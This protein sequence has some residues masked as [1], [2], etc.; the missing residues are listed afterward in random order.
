MF[1]IVSIPAAAQETPETGGPG[2]AL[3]FERSVP[4]D[5]QTEI[6]APEIT[7]DRQG[8]LVGIPQP[9]REGEV[10]TFSTFSAMRVAPRPITA[11]VLLDNPGALSSLSVGG[12]VRTAVRRVQSE[13]QNVINDLEQLGVADTQSISL[14]ANALVVNIDASQIAE[15]EALPGVRAVVPDQIGYLDN[16]NSVPFINAVSA[17]QAAGGYTGTGVRIGIIDSGIDY[18]HANFG[19]SGDPAVFTANNTFTIADIGFNGSKVVGGYDFVGSSW[20]SGGPLV[21]DDDPV[22]CNGH[23]SHVAGTAAGF[24]VDDSGNT[25]TG[26]Y[27]ASTDFSSMIIGPGVAPE[28]DL[29]ALKIGGCG[30]AVSFA[31][32][33]LALEFAID[34]NGD[35]NPSDHLDVINNSYGGAYGTALEIL[36]DQMDYAA[37]MGVIVVSS[38]GNEG[39]VYFVT[40]APGMSEWSISTASSVS[41]TTFNGLEITTGDGSFLNYPATIAASLSQ[42]GALGSFG[43]YSLRLVGGTGN[44]QGCAVGDYTG[45]TGEVG[46]IIWSAAASGCGSGTRMTNAVNAGNVAG[47]VVVTANPADFPFISLA[48]TY[49]GGP[50][51]IPCVSVSGADGALLQANP[52]NFTVRFDD[53]LRASL[54]VSLGDTLSNF[55]SRGPRTQTGTGEVILKPD[56]TAPGQNIVSTGVGTGNGPTTLS[57]TSM[58]SPHIT[59]VAALMRQ[60]HP[61]WSVSEIKA[62]M[63]N[64]AFHDLWTQPDQSG[65]NYGLS[66]IGAGR[67]DIALALNTDVIAYDSSYP[68]RVSVSFGLVEIV[69]TVSI[70]RSITIANKGSSSETYDVSFQQANDTPG[71]SFSVSP[72]Q[73]T[74]GAGGTASVQVT[75]TANKAAMANANIPDP[76]TPLTQNGAF[77]NL[78]RHRI[79]EEGGY[80]VLD[81]LSSVSDLRVPVHAAPRPAS[82]MAADGDLVIGGGDTG[83]AA[84]RLAGNEVFTGLNFPQDVISLVTAFELVD[85][86]PHGQ[87]PLLDGADIQYIGVTSDYLANWAACS[88]DTT[89][90]INNTTVYFG[91]TTYG[92][93][94]TA[95]G[96]NTW[97]DIGVDSDENNAYNATVFNFETG[98]LINADFTDTIMSWVT[99]GNSWLTSNGAPVSAYFINDLP[100]NTLE[101]YVFNNNVLVFPVAATRLG[102]SAANTDFWFDVRAF[103]DFFEGDWLPEAA[104]YWYTYD[105]ANPAYS[106]NDAAGLAGGPY[107]GVPTWDDLDGNFIPVDYTVAGLTDLPPILLLHHHNAADASVGRAE[108]V[109]VLRGTEMDAVVTK[110]VDDETPAEAATV[111]FEITVANSG[112]GILQDPVLVDRLPIGLTY[113]SDTCPGTSIV[114][115]GALGTEI[116]CEM[117][118]SSIPSGFSI[119]YD[120]VATVDSGTSGTTLTNQVALTSYNTATVDI[121]VS[122][123]LSA[124][125]VCVDGIDGQC[126][127]PPT[128]ANIQEGSGV[129]ITPG[130]TIDTPI[131]T[132]S[133]T[134]DQPVRGG[135]GVDGAANPANYRVLAEGSTPGFQTNTCTTAVNPGDTAVP[136]TVSYDDATFTTTLTITSAPLPDGNYRF[137][138]CGSTSITNLAGVSLDGNGDG[139]AGDDAIV[140]FAAASGT[141]G[142]GT[143]GS[144]SAGGAGGDSGV[145]SP[146]QL[147]GLELP[148]TGETPWWYPSPIALL[149]LSGGVLLAGAAVYRRRKSHQ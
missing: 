89:C 67:V 138:V 17:W 47:L 45:F 79:M 139:T 115:P 131:S 85:E 122:N 81:S 22:D 1:C 106:F 99:N 68:E 24:G 39:D 144:G 13:Q 5:T 140:D 126:N 136:F 63:M 14:T 143:G 128:V 53:S 69:D 33:A 94:S 116:E 119:S 109:Q 100:A 3:G 137:M 34:P 93:W 18:T 110:S 31:A 102:L 21:G 132:I 48:C 2:G 29:Y 96:F 60:A 107:T 123:N 51:P 74:V 127:L 145:L 105:I 135:A 134:F 91:V 62:L 28:A 49:N 84:L 108:V 117:L 35:D 124:I 90:A 70:T 40:G 23:G 26:P 83:F 54:G 57:G 27:D 149:A 103:S 65:D 111:T 64:T 92:S 148:A 72:A 113:V 141:G 46:L 58:A 8:F 36:T 88:G 130:S 9:T 104:P 37:Q 4:Q 114:T 11:V 101:T 42:G 12:D 16:A 30:N 87:D 20:V 129:S 7:P 77:G 147:E 82:D 55:T 43:P 112:P 95:S 125:N 142:G 10:S 56:I 61:G 118:G 71:V 80:V 78:P 98:F 41:D 97:I 75:L 25:Y 44:A 133:V 59:G 86:N 76:T 50:S 120:I 121:D 38:A 6:G 15:I 52:G 73:V 66:R 19:G 32:A 146:E